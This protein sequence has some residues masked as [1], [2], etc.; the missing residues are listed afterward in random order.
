MDV[1]LSSDWRI[2]LAMGVCLNE[3]ELVN[4]LSCE[5]RIEEKPSKRSERAG[6]EESG[7]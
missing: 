7:E 1:L 4:R 2:Y 5:R 3:V 6:G